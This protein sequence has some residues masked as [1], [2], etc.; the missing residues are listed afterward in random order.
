LLSAVREA[1]DARDYEVVIN[2]RIDVLLAD[3]ERP[4]LELLD[5]ALGRARAYLEAGADCVYPIFLWEEEAAARFVADTGGPVNLLAVANDRSLADLAA[6]GVAR[7][8]YGPLVFRRLFAQ[9]DS[10]LATDFRR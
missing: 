1:A 6:L 4:Q 10:L 3:R 9:L 5:E 7:V 8:S 2:A